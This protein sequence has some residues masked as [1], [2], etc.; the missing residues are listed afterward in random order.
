MYTLLKQRRL[1]WLGHVCRM[2]DGRIPKDL[3]CELASGTRARGRP[4]LSFKDVVKRDM[5]DM[6]IDINTSETLT[7]SRT[8]WR[9]VVKK[10]LQR[11]EEKQRLQSEHRRF[12][13]KAKK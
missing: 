5:K 12:K 8:L 6:D 2:P 7:S 9:Q 1:R 13:R 11:G 4:H 3:Y 10:G